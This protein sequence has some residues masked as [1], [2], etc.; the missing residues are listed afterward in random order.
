MKQSPAPPVQSLL[1]PS[2]ALCAAL[3]QSL[4]QR[5]PLPCHPVPTR[6]RHAR[7][8]A[9]RAFTRPAPSPQP[10]C[11]RGVLPEHSILLLALLVISSSPRPT[12]LQTRSNISLQLPSQA[13]ISET[14]PALPHS[15]SISTDK[16][17]LPSL[18][19]RETTTHSVATNRP[20]TVG[21]IA[22]DARCCSKPSRTLPPRPC[23]A[24][25]VACASD[26][27]VPRSSTHSP[28]WLRAISFVS[29]RTCRVPAS[30]QRSSLPLRATFTAQ[31]RSLYLALGPT[32]QTGSRVSHLAR[33][34]RD[35]YCAR[36]D[37]YRV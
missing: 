5:R 25:A 35:D 19:A 27:Y 13:N 4:L 6:A 9:K 29:S 37:L 1:S 21:A 34:P 33:P 26:R 32:L 11:F 16:Q 31:G 24:A 3:P 23:P 18:S 2:I 17:T 12:P 14:R 36:H 7:Y 15:P 10:P 28:T 22:N 30:A 8:R 20:Q